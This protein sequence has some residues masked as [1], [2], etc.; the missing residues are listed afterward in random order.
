MTEIPTELQS[1][2]SKLSLTQYRKLL[3]GNYVRK[4]LEKIGCQFDS[5]TF[6]N[7]PSKYLCNVFIA[8]EY[9][10]NENEEF[11]LLNVKVGNV[12]TSDF[13][14]RKNETIESFFK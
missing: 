6:S 13:T 3:I 2:L 9:E 14:L 11:S 12:L 7:I 8:N 5:E 4:I 1:N 10:D